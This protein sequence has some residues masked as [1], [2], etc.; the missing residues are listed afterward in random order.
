MKVEIGKYR[1]WFGPYQLAELLCFWAKSE[2][3]EYGFSCKPKWVHNFGEF[4][5]HGSIKPEVKVG[6]SKSVMDSDRKVTW[7]YEILSWIDSK[8]SRTVKVRID[9]WDSYSA[10]NT[11]AYVIHPVLIQLK[12]N[13]QSYFEVDDEDVPEELRRTSGENS[14]DTAIKRHLW[15]LDEM[16]F[17]FKHHID[18][19]WENQFHTGKL[20]TYF[21][22]REDGNFQMMHGENHTFKVDYDGLMAM[23]ARIDN[24]TRLFGKY[25]RNLWS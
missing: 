20:D 12:E 2:K 1:N 22:K 19:D 14:E 6:E 3:D 10:Y 13:S 17:A 9:P 4:L 25:Y 18:D 11:L 8:K 16:I 15:V 21:V 23:H 7:L 5:A 24:G